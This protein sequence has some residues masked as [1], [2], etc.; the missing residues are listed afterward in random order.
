MKPPGSI[1]M[2]WIAPRLHT[3]A[4]QMIAEKFAEKFATIA[5]RG[6]IHWYR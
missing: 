6:C 2:V 3:E 4:A 5:F 1:E